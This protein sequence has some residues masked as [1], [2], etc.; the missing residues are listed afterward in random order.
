MLCHMRIDG[1]RILLVVLA[2]AAC[3]HAQH[4]AGGGGGGQ[5]GGNSAPVPAQVRKT[6]DATLGPAAQVTSEEEGGVTIYE[7]ATQTKLELELSAA[8]VLQRTEVAVPAAVLPT[9]VTAAL[10]GKGTISEAE[11]VVMPTGVAF[12]VEIDDTEYVVDPS[13]KIL[14]HETEVDVK[15]EDRD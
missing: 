11:V 10:A 14:S 12:E 9:A 2:T 5:S 13:G 8:G 3:G 15:G 4:G 7:A 1:M 6:V